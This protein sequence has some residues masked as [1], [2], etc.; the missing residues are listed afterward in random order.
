MHIY[1]M[2]LGSLLGLMFFSISL[3]ASRLQLIERAEGGDAE[4]QYE[5]GMSLVKKDKGAALD[6]ISLAAENKHGDAMHFM[7]MQEV[8][9]KNGA[10]TPENVRS[11]FPRLLHIAEI[12]SAAADSQ[13]GVILFAEGRASEARQWLE[14]A[15]AKGLTSAKYNLAQVY[16]SL[17]SSKTLRAEELH[18]YNYKIENLLLDAASAGILLAQY[19]LGNFLIDKGDSKSGIVWIKQAA[20]SDH[21]PSQYILARYYFYTEKNLPLAI[22]WVQISIDKQLTL[23]KLNFLG[24]IY[25]SDDFERDL[26]KNK[27]NLHDYHKQ[28]FELIEQAAIGGLATAQYT[29]GSLHELGKGVEENQ[30]IANYWYESSAK[31]GFVRAIEKLQSNAQAEREAYLTG[32]DRAAQLEKSK[33]CLSKFIN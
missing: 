13:I 14:K 21:A 6:W 1:I 16:Q 23:E 3:Q 26:G 30:D 17:V 19:D 12:G 20:E 32:K 7:L 15:V 33:R 22:R 24:Y 10:I 28:G 25:L 18:R 4:S 27:S 9:S 8:L 29:L 5:L 11:V 31:L 2:K